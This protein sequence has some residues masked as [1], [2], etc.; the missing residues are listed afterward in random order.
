MTVPRHRVAVV[1]LVLNE[2]GHILLVNDARRGWEFPGGLVE[3]GESVE[4]AAIREVDE[5][6]GIRIELKAFRLVAHDL[7]RVTFL[8]LFV[9][10]SIE[11][12]LCASDETLEAGYYTIHEALEK[13]APKP[14]NEHIVRCLDPSVAP[15][16]VEYRDF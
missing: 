1:V 6:T 3:E 12:T 11:G 10:K 2:D 14:Y 5:E 9:G 13:I 7:A 15:C 16:F 4:A 8:F